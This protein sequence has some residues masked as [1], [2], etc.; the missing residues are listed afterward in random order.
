MWYSLYIINKE[1]ID[2]AHAKATKWYITVPMSIYFGWITVASSLN[3]A[4]VLS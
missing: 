3:I 1:L 4:S 2:Y